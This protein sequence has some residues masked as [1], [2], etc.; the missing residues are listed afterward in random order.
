MRVQ[1]PRLD[2]RLGRNINHDL[3]SRLFPVQAADVVP[4]SV[5]HERHVPVFDQGQLG[6]C[7][8]NAGIGCLAT[9][10]F[11]DE[12]QKLPAGKYTLD[13]AGAVKL[14]SDATVADPYDG[15]YPPEDTGSDGLSIAKV[16]QNA[17]IISGYQHAFSLN[18]AIKALTLAPFITGT[19]WYNDMFTPDASGRVQASG[20]LAGGHE[21]VADELDI[22]R[23]RIW[24]TNSWGASWGIGGRFYMAFGD[25]SGLLENNGDV[26]VFVPATQPAPVPVPPAVD[27][28]DVTLASQVRDWSK[29]HHAGSNAKAA[30]AV[31]AWIIAKNL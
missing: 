21:Y 25:Y 24:F 22:E 12:Y 4:K 28:R 13:E 11:Y 1:L 18:D 14:Y 3:R 30:K 10:N 27:P 9:G 17:H 31:Q 20:A 5:R 19:F 6:S 15:T 2:H 23:E 26:T 8:G 16:L 29:A 7:T